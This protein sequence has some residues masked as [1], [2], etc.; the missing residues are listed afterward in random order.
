MIFVEELLRKHA[1]IIK[2]FNNQIK[3]HFLSPYYEVFK[4]K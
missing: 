4:I 3:N 2:Y 1:N